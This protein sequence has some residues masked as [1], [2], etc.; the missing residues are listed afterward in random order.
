MWTIRILTYL[1]FIGVLFCYAWF[2]N[3]V[4]PCCG[5]LVGYTA[6]RW[7][8]PT[9]WHS[10]KTLSCICYSIIIFCICTT[11]CLP[12]GVSLLWSVVVSL[13]L[14]YCLYHYQNL[15]DKIINNVTE[16]EKI[17]AMTEEELRNYAKSKGLSEM[18]V[19]TLILRIIHNYRWVEIRK[20]RN[21][22]RRGIDY[23]KK[24]IEKKLNIK[25]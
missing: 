22:T 10:Q 19:D 18:M 11:L 4:I 3:K 1:L 2:I 8:F 23:H 24:I 7:C 25:L 20:E 17:Y 14:T 16:K 9:T 6:I 12:I 21:Y 15:C 5:L 13:I